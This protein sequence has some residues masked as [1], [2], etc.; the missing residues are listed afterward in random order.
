MVFS[1]INSNHI[2]HLGGSKSTVKSRGTSNLPCF[3]AT[4]IDYVTFG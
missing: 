1:I 2:S 3:S 4:F